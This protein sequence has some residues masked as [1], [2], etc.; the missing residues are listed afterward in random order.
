MQP[1]AAA[2]Q[3]LLAASVRIPDTAPQNALQNAYSQFKDNQEGITADYIKALADMDSQLFGITVVTADGRFFDIDD[4]WSNFSIQSISKVFTYAKIIQE[5]TWLYETGTPAKSGVG[6]GIVAVVPGKLAIGVFSP[7]LD[8]FGNS[9]SGQL[10]AAT[11]IQEL[12][13]P[14]YDPANAN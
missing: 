1:A 5:H 10:A 3:Q 9:V 6:G 11:I 8:S 4:T 14:P 2:Q 12:G 7:S 13:L